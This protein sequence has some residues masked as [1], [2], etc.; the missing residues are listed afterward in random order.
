VGP[1]VENIH[2]LN[3]IL[4]FK[5][6]KKYSTCTKKQDPNKWQKIALLLSTQV[7]FPKSGLFMMVN[8]KG[9]CRTV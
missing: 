5:K 2:H 4:I 7:P 1:G 9:K 3:L 6:S 8:M